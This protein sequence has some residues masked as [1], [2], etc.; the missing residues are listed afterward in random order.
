MNLAADEELRAEITKRIFEL[1]FKQ[2]FL[3]NDASE[4]GYK[5]DKHRLSKYLKGKGGLT[6]EQVLWL[7][8]R[9]GIDVVY[10]IGKPVISGG[11]LSFKVA[12]Y[13]E[14]MAIKKLNFV[15]SKHGKTK[16]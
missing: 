16:S 14:E 15:F 8:V 11:I 7:A 5:L 1:G 3:V 6:E 12:P 10:G 4:R 9:L 2:S 13:N